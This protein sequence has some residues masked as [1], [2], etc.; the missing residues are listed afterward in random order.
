[1]S[2]N[3][4]EIDSIDKIINGLFKG[5]YRMGIVTAGNCPYNSATRSALPGMLSAINGK[6]NLRQ[7]AIGNLNNA[8]TTFDAA[9]K[10]LKN[11]CSHY[12]QIVNFKIM[13]AI[14]TKDVRPYYDVAIDSTELPPL[15]TEID[16]ENFANAIVAGEVTLLAAGFPAMLDYTAAGVT[17]L[18]GP[19]A[20]AKSAKNLKTG[21]LITAESNLNALVGPSTTFLVDM[22]DQ[23]EFFFRNN[24]PATMR[25]NSILWGNEYEA[26]KVLTGFNIHGEIEI[27]KVDAFGATYRIGKL[28]TK[29]KKAAVEG[30]T[31]VADAHGNCVLETVQDGDLFLIC[32]LAGYVTQNI[33][34]IIVAGEDQVIT[35]IFV[36]AT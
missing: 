10:N 14:Y 19:Y 15:T 20:T 6:Y 34:I 4:V 9:E 27:T 7:I 5:N 25:S 12:F 8:V 30:V 3:R 1:M 18:L 16:I 13:D 33:P 2:I 35:V 11:Y 26:S 32:E 21:L 36:P 24:I 22:Q 17:A 29:K 31:G 28:L 23:T